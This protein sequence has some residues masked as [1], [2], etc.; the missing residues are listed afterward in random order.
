[1]S[2]SADVAVVGAGIMGCSIALELSRRGRRVLVLDLAAA[3]GEGSTSASSAIVRFNYS[4][5]AGVV[6]AWESSRHWVGW[7]DHLGTRDANGLARFRRTGMVCLDVPV[8][9]RADALRPLGEIGVPYEELDPD[10]LVDRFPWLDNGSYWPNKRVT[11]EAFWSGPTGRLGGFWTPDAGFVD[12][13]RLATQNLAA[14]ARATGAEFRFRSPV[15]GLHGGPRESWV[16]ELGGGERVEAGVV[17]NAAGPWS[18]ALNRLA[19]VGDEFTVRVRPMRQEVHEVPAPEGYSSDGHWGPAV[20]DLDLGTYWRPGPHN[21]LLIGGTEPECDGF[22]WLDDPDAAGP[23]VTRLRYEAQVTRAARRLPG[24]R[25]PPRPRGVAGVYDVAEDWTPIYDRT[26]AP[27]FYVAMGTSGNQFKNGPVV[28]GFLAA[29]IEHVEGGHDHD[30]EPAHHRGE[31]TGLDI[32][33]GAFSRKR[34][35]NR[36]SSGTVL[37]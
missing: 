6:A 32:D 20:A 10:E 30:V 22:E 2:M 31:L 25:V 27:G 1:M 21:T 36:A 4:T 19:G 14:A 37:G 11:D 5:A 12:D 26:D 35:R 34:P 18:S 7:Q 23:T 15:V 3:P 29:I 8:L 33:L 17:V 24:L 9:P 28:G 16:L 13:P